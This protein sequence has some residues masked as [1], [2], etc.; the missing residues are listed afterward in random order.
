MIL[1]KVEYDEKTVEAQ[2]IKDTR[3]LRKF[4]IMLNFAKSGEFAEVS[5]YNFLLIKSKVQRFSFNE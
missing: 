4:C 5:L 1:D 2:C 3:E